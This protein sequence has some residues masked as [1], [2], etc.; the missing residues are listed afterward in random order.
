MEKM[1]ATALILQ[2]GNLCTSLARSVK[3]AAWCLLAVS[4][5]AAQSSFAQE[6]EP[7]T[8]AY[9][10]NLVSDKYGN[11][12]L[13][14]V[15]TELSKTEQGYAVSSATKAQGIAAILMGSN[16]Q[17]ACEFGVNEGRAISSAYAG[18]RRDLKDYVVGFDWQARK[19]TFEDGDSLDMPQGYV[20]DNCNMLF[21]AALLRDAEQLDDSLYIVDGKSKRIRGY[22]L[23]SSTEELLATDF[24]EFNT[25][26]IV[27]E[28]ELKPERT[29]TFWL[30]PEYSYVP[31]K[32]VERRRK[33]TTTF[34]VDDIES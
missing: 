2:T 14:K 19:V 31:L 5:G 21:A 18:G 6:L 26:K 15:E 10:I 28:R 3:N 8:I 25:R 7:I 34:M 33:R 24:G 9:T 1:L 4:L 20:V 27:F 16:Y 12:T 29:L 17:E 23:K 32:M 22:R 30:S 11:A 13:G